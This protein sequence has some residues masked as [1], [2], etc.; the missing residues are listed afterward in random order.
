M[1]TA[2]GPQVFRCWADS[3]QHRLSHEVTGSTWLNVAN[4]LQKSPW[5]Y[6]MRHL[7]DKLVEHLALLREL[8]PEEWGNLSWANQQH[9]AFCR[10][11]VL[12]TARC[13]NTMDADDLS[14]QF[15]AEMVIGECS[16][17]DVKLQSGIQVVFQILGWL[18]GIF[19]AV[20]SHQDIQNANHTLL[21][22]RRAGSAGQAR[23]YRD[24][25]AIRETELMLH[26]DDLRKI[27]HI[28]AGA[29]GTFA[30]SS[31]TDTPT[32]DFC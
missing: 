18:T 27:H 24:E 26:D 22:I 15:L 29:F 13:I 12:T 7:D 5:L 10:N 21:Q 19:D 8:A 6:F 17:P 23:D 9:R 28:L 3:L 2:N 1:R 4:E 14:L 32:T 30:T 11:V 25:P 20:C 31:R 16:H